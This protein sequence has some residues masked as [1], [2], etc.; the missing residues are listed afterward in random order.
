MWIGKVANVLFFF[1][2]L[3]LKLEQ[4]KGVSSVIV[5]RILTP[6]I[7]S[8]DRFRLIDHG[9]LTTQKRGLLMIAKV[10]Q[11]IANGIE[12]GEGFRFDVTNQRYVLHFIPTD[13]YLAPLNS[14]IASHHHQL[15]SF[16]SALIGTADTNPPLLV[17]KPFN[18][19]AV[20]AIMMRAPVYADDL[21]IAMEFGANAVR[22]L[23]KFF[24]F[25]FFYT[26]KTKRWCL[27]AAMLVRLVF[28]SCIDPV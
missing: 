14:L 10:L 17:E 20:K 11:Q 7:I 15:V 22:F 19:S 9:L 27:A 3:F 25:S 16:L 4:K 2:F 23:L 26:N 28:V 13:H 1:F 12:F 8:P 6:A 24:V 18:R 21:L 5:L